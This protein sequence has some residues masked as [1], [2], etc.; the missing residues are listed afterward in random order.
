MHTY[1]YIYTL[2]THRYLYVYTYIHTYSNETTYIH[3]HIHLRMCVLG[4]SKSGIM[5]ILGCHHATSA[6]GSTFSGCSWSGTRISTTSATWTRCSPAPAFLGKLDSAISIHSGV[7]VGGVLTIRI[8]VVGGY[9]K[10]P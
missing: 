5:S 6:S 2:V 7:H 1:I 9:I 4:P 10:A 8:L 3:I